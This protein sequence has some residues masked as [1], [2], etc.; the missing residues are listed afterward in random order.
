MVHVGLHLVALICS[1]MHGPLIC[2][3]QWLQKISSGSE[4]TL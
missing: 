4:A 1:T 2:G 3:V